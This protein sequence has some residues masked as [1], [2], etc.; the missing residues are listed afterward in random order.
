[1]NKTKKTCLGLQVPKERSATE[2]PNHW[3]RAKLKQSAS[4]LQTPLE[5]HQ[6]DL[7]SIIAVPSQP[8]VGDVRRY[9]GALVCPYHYHRVSSHPRN[10]NRHPH[11]HRYYPLVNGDLLI[12]AC[13]WSR[14]NCHN[15]PAVRLRLYHIRVARSSLGER[16]KVVRR[17]C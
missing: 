9:R 2:L 13:P 10:S 12:S 1:M 7:S 15:H 3:Y 11:C 16:H 8:E 17:R 14:S 5:K 4:K 6:L